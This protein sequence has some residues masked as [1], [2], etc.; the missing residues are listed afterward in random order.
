MARWVHALAA[1]AAGAGVFAA[2]PEAVLTAGAIGPAAQTVAPQ[3][4][5]STTQPAP[6]A[7][8][9]PATAPIGNDRPYGSDY[10]IVVNRSIFARGGTPAAARAK[11]PMNA[12]PGPEAGLGLKGIFEGDGR[13]TAFIEDLASHQTKRL[14]VGDAIAAGRI[15]AMTL[16]ALEYEAGGKSTMVQVGQNLL[17]AALP[18]PQPPATQ[19]AAPPGGPPGQP[20]P[21]MPG[22]P[23][24]PMPPG[25]KV[26]RGMP[27]MVQP[28]G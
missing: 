18:P 9:Q 16:A 11:G 21:G 1:T 19:P 12:A 6:P 22:G 13:F 14:N 25:M 4:P 24:G 5:P 10:Q 8:S 15:K 26:P 2:A 20:Q 28:S 7:A 27:V 3:L 23:G 17:G